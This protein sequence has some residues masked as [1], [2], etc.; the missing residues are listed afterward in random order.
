MLPIITV[1]VELWAGNVVLR[2]IVYSKYGDHK[3]ILV[4]AQKN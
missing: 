4:C 2:K 3:A 1:I